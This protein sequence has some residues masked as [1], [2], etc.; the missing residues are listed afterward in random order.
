MGGVGVRGG[1]G[2]ASA[3]PHSGGIG[4]EAADSLPSLLRLE[5]RG[6]ARTNC[7]DSLDRW[8]GVFWLEGGKEKGRVFFFTCMVNTNTRIINTNKT[9]ISMQYCHSTN[10]A[11]FMMG[12]HAPE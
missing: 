9:H 1:G 12:I 7:I 4:E 2:A 10:V 3:S 11:Q 8:V 6:V 5:Q